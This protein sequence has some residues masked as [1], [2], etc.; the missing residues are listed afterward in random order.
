MYSKI[1]TASLSGMKGVPIIVETH[2]THGLPITQVV[3][4]ADTTIQES[5]ER[6]RSAIHNIDLDY[7]KGKVIVNLSPAN[8]RKRGS[9][10]DLP[11]AMGILMAV[12]EIKYDLD[13]ASCKDKGKKRAFIGEL[14]LEGDIC[15][16]TGVLPMLIGLKE[17]GI[18]EVYIPSENRREAGLVK[19]MTIYCA[20]HIKDIINHV[21]DSE[22]LSKVDSYED[23]LL[24]NEVELESERL[25]DFSQI[26]GQHS[27]KR[28]I[29]VS[30]S[31]KHGILMTGSPGT[32]KTMLSERIITIMPQMS[33][34]EMIET[35]IIYSVSGLLNSDIPIIENRP[36]RSPHYKITRGGLIGGGGN[37]KAG[38]ITLAHNGVLFL[39]EVGEF[40]SSV[41][42]LLRTPI[43]HKTVSHFRNGMNYVYPCDF[44]LVAA[45]NP[46][47][48]GYYGDPLI[49]CKCTDYEID[50]YKKKISGPILDRI[51]MHIF[52]D[53]VKFAEWDGEESEDS[54]Q[55]RDIVLR[56]RE[57]QQERMKRL[58][59][60]SQRS[61]NEKNLKIICKLTQK[62]MCILQNMY[63]KFH[64]NPRKLNKLLMVARTIADIEKSEM[65]TSEHIAEAIQY[66]VRV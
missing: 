6:I 10:F 34:D 13:D 11:I 17:E 18:S 56:V 37:P 7:P 26:K 65:V 41:I 40:D 58:K 50:R 16:V 54:K 51:D 8:I 20:S 35:T 24:V 29:T 23:A 39:D 1:Y 47:K 15:S 53:N 46:C 57:V 31:G 66:R 42:E 49:E 19:G 52:L 36:F 9:H 27:A 12:G 3:G 43:E 14:S 33:Y 28:A 59:I 64:L 21:K 45:Q 61:L 62:E 4:L 32:G 22:R 63:E 25:L 44:M 48:C 5:K 2:I 30:V 55:I 60:K 38:E